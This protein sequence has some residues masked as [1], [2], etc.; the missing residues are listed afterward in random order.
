MPPL[1][2]HV[3]LAVFTLGCSE[4]L[5]LPPGD[6]LRVAVAPLSLP[7]LSEVCFDLRVTNGPDGTGDVVWSRGTPGLNGGTPDDDALCS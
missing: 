5:M 4:G 2:R 6:D 7:G 1:F 3:L